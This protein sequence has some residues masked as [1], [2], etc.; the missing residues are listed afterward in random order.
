MNAPIAYLPTSKHD[1]STEIRVANSYSIKDSLKARGYR[2]NGR[3]KC[4]SVVVDNG[5]LAT[6][7]EAL[8]ADGAA[9]NETL[10]QYHLGNATYEEMVAAVEAMRKAA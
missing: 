10:V 8:K 5:D 3:D 7:I 4:W 2:F 6:E 1:S 9:I